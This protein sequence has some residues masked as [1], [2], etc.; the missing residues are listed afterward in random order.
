MMPMLHLY[1]WP[2]LVLLHYYIC[3]ILALELGKLAYLAPHLV[4]PCECMQHRQ[5]F[6]GL[7]PKC[8]AQTKCLKH[9]VRSMA[10]AARGRLQW[11][12][13]TALRYMHFCVVQARSGPLRHYGCAHWVM[14]AWGFTNSWG[15]LWPNSSKRTLITQHIKW[16]EISLVLVD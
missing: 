11:Q 13:H 7:A 2:I 3:F 1:S 16:Q 10:D 12:P 14:H 9:P 8:H 15:S 5:N 4:S 6:L